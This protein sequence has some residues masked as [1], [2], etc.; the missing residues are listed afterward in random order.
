M[1]LTHEHEAIRSTL[2]RFIAE[3]INPHVDAWEAAEI[4]PAHEVFAGLG[5]LGLLGL[6]KPPEFG[7][8]GLDYSYSVVMAEA[9]EIGR[10]HV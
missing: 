2:K 1:Q 6:T 7:G 5:K 9:L 3:E 8:M 4:F 10:A